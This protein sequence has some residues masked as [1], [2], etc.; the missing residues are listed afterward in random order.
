[1]DELPATGVETH[2]PRCGTLIPSGESECPVCR[3]ARGPMMLS[4]D[5]I[6]LL[7]I[8][9]LIPFF[10]VTGFAVRSYHA[11]KARLAQEWYARGAANLRAA[12]AGVAIEDF[13]TALVFAPDTPL[14]RLRLAQALL[15]AQSF[16]E[17]RAYLLG[18][19]EKEPGDG[20]VNL[21]LARLAV[22]RN[23][24]NGAIRYFHNAVYG[25][26]ETDPP[27]RRRAARLELCEFL[28]RAGAK[29]EAQSEL[30]ALA[31]DLPPGA[32][33]H[34]NVAR[35]FLQVED[36]DRAIQEYRAVLQ[37]EPGNAEVL[38]GA[39]KAAFLKM[40]YARARQFLQQAVRANSGDTA[41]LQLLE[42]TNL[43]LASDPYLPRLSTTEQARRV[44]RAYEQAQKRL[45]ECIAAQ[46]T[47]AEPRDLQQRLNKV[48]P[49]AR[50]ARLRRDP[51]Q[52][53][54]VMDLVFE[55]EDRTAQICGLP[56]GLDRVLWLLAR[57]HRGRDQ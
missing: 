40:D 31:A 23:D 36:Y 48:R 39:G 3:E 51:D 32:A 53:T 56:A 9:A 46:P 44:A 27:A 22:R 24:V 47:A 29:Q 33:T 18:L 43:I 52:M 15:A 16:E 17:G 2:C 57:Q 21:E 49:L 11:R 34:L 30:V 8:L 10:A 42:T 38:A 1:M 45:Q 14:Y 6:L 28:V 7:S 13:R 19:W 12:R 4:R 35:L 25:V 50:T 41:S 5:T 54:V 26:W 37:A 20:V 55:T